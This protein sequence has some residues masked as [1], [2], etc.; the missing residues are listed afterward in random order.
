[1]EFEHVEYETRRLM[2]LLQTHRDLFRFINADIKKPA[3]GSSYGVLLPCDDE[4][5]EVII[6]SPLPRV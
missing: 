4:D 1:M 3:K 2:S 6:T 5:S